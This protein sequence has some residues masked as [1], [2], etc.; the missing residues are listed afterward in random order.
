VDQKIFS[1]GPSPEGFTIFMVIS[2]LRMVHGPISKKYNHFQTVG[3]AANQ[4]SGCT[5]F[6]YG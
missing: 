1:N 4:S 5:S 2:Q 6:V 3:M